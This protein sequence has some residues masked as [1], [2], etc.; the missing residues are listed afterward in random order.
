MREHRSLSENLFP[1]NQDSRQ[2][3]LGI[4]FSDLSV[5]ILMNRKVPISPNPR[6][7]DLFDSKILWAEAKDSVKTFECLSFF[8]WQDRAAGLPPTIQILRKVAMNVRRNASRSDRALIRRLSPR[9]ARWTSHTLFPL[10]YR[11]DLRSRL[12]RTTT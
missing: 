6:S 8:L 9:A 12:R 1:E 4:E 5:P 10:P 2:T 3:D 7:G 11:C